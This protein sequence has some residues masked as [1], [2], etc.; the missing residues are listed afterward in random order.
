[1][2]LNLAIVDRLRVAG[3]I[4]LVM[5]VAAIAE[6]IDHH[7]FLEPLTEIE[8]DLRHADCCFRIVAVHVKNR[9]LH[10][11][12]DVGGIRRGPRF[13]RQRRK[14]NLIVDD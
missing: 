6:H 9:R 4:A 10:H 5:S 11:A 8:G 7:V 12:R 1:M 14:S 2:L 3:I 13:V